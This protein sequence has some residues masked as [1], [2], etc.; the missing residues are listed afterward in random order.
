[1]KCA[2]CNADIRTPFLLQRAS[3]Q[4]LEV[5]WNTVE[6]RPGD[7]AFCNESHHARHLAEHQAKPLPGGKH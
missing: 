5:S 1:M 6:M 3:T 4:A 2:Y 7:L